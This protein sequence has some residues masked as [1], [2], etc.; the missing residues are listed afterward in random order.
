M[1]QA[2]LERHVFI[3]SSSHS[4]M[5]R[6]V[7][8]LKSTKLQ[9]VVAMATTRKLRAH[10][11]SFFLFHFADSVSFLRPRSRTTAGEVLLIDA[12]PI[13]ALMKLSFVSR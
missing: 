10:L 2:T 3:H 1:T 8:R 11:I 13:D 12:L 4:F 9:E 6:H 5:N 7:F